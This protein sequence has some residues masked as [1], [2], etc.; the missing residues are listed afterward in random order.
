MKGLVQT[1]AYNLAEAARRLETLAE[2]LD[3]LL[4]MYWAREDE[5]LARPRRRRS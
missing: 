1:A 4:K 2:G 3:A 5:K